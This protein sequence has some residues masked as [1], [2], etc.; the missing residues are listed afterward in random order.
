MLNR[1]AKNY[2]ALTWGKSVYKQRKTWLQTGDFVHMAK[3]TIARLCV[4]RLFIPAFCAAYT[5][6][7]PHLKHGLIPLLKC[8]FS[9]LPTPFTTITTT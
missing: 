8:R 2:S 9:T 7:F 4:S 6:T 1:Y 3:Q 5:P